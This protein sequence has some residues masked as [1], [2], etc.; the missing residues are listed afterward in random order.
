MN[1]SLVYSEWKKRAKPRTVPLVVLGYFT[2][3]KYVFQALTPDQQSLKSVWEKKLFSV[4]IIKSYLFI[5]ADIQKHVIEICNRKSLGHSRAHQVDFCC[6][7]VL[8][9]F[10]SSQFTPLHSSFAQ[11]CLSLPTTRSFL[12]FSLVKILPGIV[13]IFSVNYHFQH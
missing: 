9:L 2:P 3:L 11:S 12:L 5:S 7:Q 1:Q 8:F 4:Y 6:K 10:L 13:Y